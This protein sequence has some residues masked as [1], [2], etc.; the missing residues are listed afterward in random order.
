MQR[1]F[2]AALAKR[3]E[4]GWRQQLKNP[5]A[6]AGARNTASSQASDRAET[7]N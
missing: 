1:G 4:G 5:W 2:A 6:S 3:V 7:R